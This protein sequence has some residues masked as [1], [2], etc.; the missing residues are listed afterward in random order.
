SA[1][2]TTSA[3]SITLMGLKSDRPVRVVSTSRPSRLVLIGTFE[4]RLVAH[5]RRSPPRASPPSPPSRWPGRTARA[6]GLTPNNGRRD[7][8]NPAGTRG[9][10]FCCTETYGFLKTRRT[11][12]RGGAGPCQRRGVDGRLHEHRRLGGHTPDRLRDVLQ[13]HPPHAV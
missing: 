13:P 3:N 12:S 1:A 4:V 8:R 9:G 11:D 5:G 6:N 7:P 2:T 10:V